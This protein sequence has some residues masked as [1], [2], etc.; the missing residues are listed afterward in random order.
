MTDNS[1]ILSSTGLILI[2]LGIALFLIPSLLKYYP[3]LEAIG[4]IHWL[5]IYV[6]KSDNF[7]FA[8][9][10]ILILTSLVLLIYSAINR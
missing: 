8:T 4:K 6:Y 10:P 7:M 9:S 1:N 3:S 5:I 2:I